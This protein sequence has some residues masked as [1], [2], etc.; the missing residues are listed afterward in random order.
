MGNRCLE[1]VNFDII[2]HKIMITYIYRAYFYKYN[3]VSYVF[4][5]FFWG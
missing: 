1:R 5:Q 4:L 3:I 2:M